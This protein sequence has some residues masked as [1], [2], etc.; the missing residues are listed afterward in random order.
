MNFVRSTIF[1][2]LCI[3]T[4]D[5]LDGCLG[6]L[7]LLWEVGIVWPVT[8]AELDRWLGTREAAH[9]HTR[10]LGLESEDHSSVW[11]LPLNSCVT[12]IKTHFLSFLPSKMKRLNLMSPSTCKRW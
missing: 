10:E 6:K 12:K 3:K 4:K 2:L 8:A 9:G 11:I 5:H 7:A 1:Q